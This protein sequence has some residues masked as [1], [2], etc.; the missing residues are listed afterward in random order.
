MIKRC[1]VLAVL[2]LFCSF[3]YSEIVRGS[4]GNAAADSYQWVMDN[5][6]AQHT[7]LSI[8]SVSYRYTTNKETGDPMLVHI[9]NQNASGQGYVFRS[10]DD[11]S[12]VPGNTITKVVPTGGV[13]YTLWGPGEIAV[14]GIGSVSNATVRYNYSYDTCNDDP[15]SS[16]TCP[17]YAAALAAEHANE[18]ATVIADEEYSI[19]KTSLPAYYEEKE[20]LKN[21]KELDNEEARARRR[22]GLDASENALTKA[23]EIS[24]EAI[25]NAMNMATRIDSYYNLAIQGGVYSDVAGY[26]AIKLPENKSALRVGLAQ[27]VLHDRMVDQQYNR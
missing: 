8:D 12:G 11:W 1:G 4:S 16:P 20:K 27:Q 13:D 10:T 17:G 15:L 2:A 23:N 22:R 5:V 26:Q 18:V 24:Q 3:C 14:E 9:Q 21:A 7:G 25:L 6:I 19:S